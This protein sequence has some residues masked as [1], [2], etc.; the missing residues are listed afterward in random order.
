MEAAEADTGYVGYYDGGAFGIPV[1]S[2]NQEATMLWLQYIGQASV[3]A[4]WAVKSARIVM[5]QT[6]EDPAVV[7]QDAKVDGYYTLMKDSG[8][9]YAGA[10][11]FPVHAQ[12]REVV[13]A[14]IYKAIAGEL[15]PA[16]A[17]DQAA[18]A[19]EQELVNL[20]YGT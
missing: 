12:V 15:T 3:Q 6:F 13:A 19:A 18:A 4:D 20:G 11:P 8:Y 1:S 5:N 10:P 7:E 9:L 17:L 2:K 16:D 14:Y